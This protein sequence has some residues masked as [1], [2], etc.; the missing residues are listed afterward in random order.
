M[1]KLLLALSLMASPLYANCDAFI[2]NTK[3]SLGEEFKVVG[4]L[5]NLNTQ[6][7]VLKRD[8]TGNGAKYVQILITPYLEMLRE[9]RISGWQI[10][11]EM[12]ERGGKTLY[13][14]VKQSKVPEKV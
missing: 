14:L 6:V 9:G 5:E 2:A 10:Q 3:E 12:C 1:K 8:D 11:E 13:I 7:I 4:V